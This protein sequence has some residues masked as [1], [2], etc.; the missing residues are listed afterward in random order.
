LRTTFRN[1][2]S[3]AFSVP[4]DELNIEI[5]AGTSD[6]IRKVTEWQIWGKRPTASRFVNK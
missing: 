4:I 2:L 6:V 5:G 3:D 1:A